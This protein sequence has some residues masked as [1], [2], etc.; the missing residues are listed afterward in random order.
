[1]HTAQQ[2]QIN[3][4]QLRQRPGSIVSHEISVL[5]FSI[6]TV[7]INVISLDPSSSCQSLKESFCCREVRRQTCDL[8]ELMEMAQ[9]MAH[10]YMFMEDD[11]RC[12][13]LMHCLMHCR[14][15]CLMHC[16]NLLCINSGTVA[17]AQA[18]NATL[19]YLLASVAE[20]S[21]MK[22]EHCPLIEWS[23][24]KRAI[25]KS[26]IERKF[27]MQPILVHLLQWT[28]ICS[29]SALVLMSCRLK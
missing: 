21:L 5:L 25:Q 9:P 15:H 11:F 16:M 1:M 17:M 10:Y 6:V 14:M 19:A 7:S 27:Y 13:S 18:S 8:I 29:Y 24:K 26:K 2:H 28:H 3:H 22:N 23:H 20:I 12:T 4:V